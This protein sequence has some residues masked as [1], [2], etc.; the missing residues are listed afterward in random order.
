M[1]NPRTTAAAMSAYPVTRAISSTRVSSVPSPLKTRTT[2][3]E[4]STARMTATTIQTSDSRTMR[5]RHC[6]R[7]TASVVSN[8]RSGLIVNSCPAKPD[9]Q[10]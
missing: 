5:W 9:P 10:E 8:C 3:M 2:T 7:R 1:N 6:R 4:A